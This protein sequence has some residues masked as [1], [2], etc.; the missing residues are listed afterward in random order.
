MPLPWPARPR[1]PATV[2][3]IGGAVGM[4]SRVSVNYQLVELETKQAIIRE[5][6][7]ARGIRLA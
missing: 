5:S 4:R 1:S 2:W 3:E 6:G 7:R